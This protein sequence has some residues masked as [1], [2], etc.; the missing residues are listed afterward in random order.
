M[1]FQVAVVIW[2]GLVR[3]EVV[4]SPIFPK[5]FSPQHQR[6]SLARMPQV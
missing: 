3:L 2:T 5:L 4:P 6:V 1:V